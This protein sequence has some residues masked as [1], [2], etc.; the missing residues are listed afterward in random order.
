MPDILIRGVE[1][2]TSCED[3]KRFFLNEY[4][5]PCYRARCSIG[6]TV[7]PYPLRFEKRGDDC[8]ILELPEHGDLIDRSE[9]LENSKA[10]GM[11]PHWIDTMDV[12]RAPIVVPADKEKAAPA[13]TGTARK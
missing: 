7:P 9:L 4:D 5:F 2:P 11:Y 13:A 3:C 12:K 10:N 8:P 6:G 1:A